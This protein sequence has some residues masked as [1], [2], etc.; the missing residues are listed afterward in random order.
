MTSYLHLI[1]NQ[2]CGQD[3]FAGKAHERIAK[4]IAK[5]IEEDKVSAIGIDGGWGS[6][7]S[8]M[9][10]MVKK[11][12]ETKSKQYY[13]FVYDAWGHQDDLQRRSILE[14]LTAFLTTPNNKKK[15][16]FDSE[17]WRNKGKDLIARKSEV[18]TKNLPKLSVG[19]IITFLVVILTP[20]F[21]I[22]AEKF[23][24]D[25]IWKIVTVALPIVVV[26]CLMLYYF[27]KNKFCKKSS[28]KQ[29]I[30]SAF[31]DTYHIYNA[32]QLEHT[33]YESIF[34]EE[35]S[36]KRFKEWMHSI[37]NELKNNQ[38]LILV[39]D[40]MDRLPKAKVQEL[41]AAIHSFF[42]EENYRH[43]KIIVPF[44]R[45]HIQSAFAE[46]DNAQEKD[47]KKGDTKRYGDDFINK[48]FNVV[49]RVSP[50]MMTDW[51]QYFIQ[52]WQIAFGENAQPDAET[53]QIYDILGGDPTPRSIIA[54]INRI[55]TIKQIMG[56]EAIPDKYIALYIF[57][58]NRIS[59]HPFD[60]IVNPNFLDGLKFLY[61]KDEELP[62]YL[63]ALFYQLP[64]KDAL[65]TIYQDRLRKALDTKNID[66]I[67]TISELPT[68]DALLQNAIPNVKNVANAVLALQQVA[69]KLTTSNWNWLY[70]Y[71]KDKSEPQLQEYQLILL[72]KISYKQAYLKK[73][74]SDLYAT[75]KFNAIDF[76]DSIIKL[77][78]IQDINPLQHIKEK[79]LSPEDYIAYV[80]H[81]KSNYKLCRFICD[82]TKL[83]EH[84]SNLDIEQL[85][86]TPATAFLG[87]QIKELANYKTHLEELVEHQ[88]N[89]ID[90]I[91]ICYN[92]LKE[93]EQPI[94]K[95]LTDI[96][97]NNCIS[98]I[99]ASH[100]FYYDFIAI[101]IARTNSN[102]HPSFNT[103]LSKTDEDT[104]KNV[105]NVIFN[106]TTYDAIMLQY[107][108][109]SSYPLIKELAHYLTL[110]PAAK[111]T[112]PQATMLLEK[113]QEI[114]N[115]TGLTPDE[116]INKLNLWNW[117]DD[118][119]PQFAK[120][121][122]EEVIEDTIQL[123]S[124]LPKLLRKQYIAYL[125]SINKEQWENH[126][127][128]RSKEYILMLKLKTR[129]IPCF[130]AFD[131][132]LEK[133]ALQQTTIEENTLRELIDLAKETK[134]PLTNTFLKV[135]GV[136][137]SDRATITTTIF[138][139]LGQYLFDYGKLETNPQSLRTIFTS[140]ILENKDC[141]EIILKN[142][143]TM[144]AIIEKT[145]D[146][147]IFKEKI[148]QLLDKQYSS[149]D[150]FVDFAKSIGI[151]KKNMIE[152]TVE[153]I[154]SIM[155]K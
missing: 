132:M 35:P 34:E 103:I 106:Y 94:N 26:L 152:K 148:E 25:T 27:I 1:S 140:S 114:L 83:D 141:M 125:N 70:Q 79:E 105:A 127:K 43:I 36:S 85:S 138:K 124:T 14:E 81:A 66:D 60:E 37:S 53:L 78:G 65:Q 68:F 102:I 146:T 56:E 20:L 154:K 54:F 129:I 24:P 111:H 119:T 31:Q 104:I 122:K 40:N 130:E 150:A 51:K 72:A 143:S 136:F 64:P 32:E 88:T 5:V 113:Y 6:G 63:A 47:K 133:Y 19:I 12:L 57:G 135:R 10:E 120:S 86:N 134:R 61:E 75:E 73:I 142:T 131:I 3:L 13:F 15:S 50:P 101:R 21:S 41:W 82:T 93:I 77:Q 80:E 145:E 139:S 153:G 44:D 33:T 55:V 123:T 67:Q 149:N 107:N 110:Q 58:E 91:A 99:N 112:L 147:S 137:C 116:L 126:I 7:K 95:L 109:F 17:I 42:A 59:E 151:E 71:V 11:E 87:E 117:E 16:I 108:R 23:I 90:D 84:L 74:I 45:K 2:P 92:K 89:N 62:K 69:D 128:S 100:P 46:E 52:Q 28:F 155:S 30:K 38:C 98:K 8:N 9:V 118:I 39:F 48:T 144:Q 97:F 49:Y 96:Q 18:H 22:I 29:A 121:I 115:A 76:Y 4:Q